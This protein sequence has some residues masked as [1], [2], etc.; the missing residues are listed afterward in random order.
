[1]CE[2]LEERNMEKQSTNESKKKNIFS[3]MASE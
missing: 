1:M 3:E 2:H